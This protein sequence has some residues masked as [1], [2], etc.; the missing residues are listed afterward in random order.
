MGESPRRGV[1]RA[2]RLPAARDRLLFRRYRDGA[3][4]FDREELM[5]CFLPLARHTAARYGHAGEPYDDLLQVACLALLRAIDR[6]DPSRGVAFSSYALP[7]MSG[8][9]KR[10]YRDRTWAMRVPRPLQELAMTVPRET[11]RMRG[12]L[13]R[14]PTV[15]ELCARLD[16][17][18]REL[19]DALGAG[20][21]CDPVS[22][23]RPRGDDASDPTLGEVVAYHEPG[24]EWADARASLDQLL[25]RLSE[26]DRELVRLRY[27]EDLTQR[28]IGRRT[29]LSQ[30]QVSRLL[31]RIV[32]ELSEAADDPRWSGNGRRR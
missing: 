27:E 31:D 13:G 20:A 12:E 8:E 14:A 26:R 29:G 32:G 2:G 30:V 23:D 19:A 3:D 18:E 16:I 1:A 24:Y 28:E 5:R 7:T 22:L 25:A 6:F 11:E 21:A 17:S 4:P 9:I 10:H 15:C